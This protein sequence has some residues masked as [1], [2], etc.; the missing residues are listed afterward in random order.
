M[1]AFKVLGD[2]LGLP[3]EDDEGDIPGDENEQ[4]VEEEQSS[5]ENESDDDE[6]EDDDGAAAGDGKSAAD[7]KIERKREREWLEAHFITAKRASD[8]GTVYKSEL[9]PDKVF[10]SK[11]KLKEFLSGKRYKRL[12]HEM[13]K[14]MRTHQDNEKLQKKATER[15]ERCME[16]KRDSEQEKL[17]NKRKRKLEEADDA[18]IARRKAQFQEKKAR[19]LARKAE[20]AGKA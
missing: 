7:A 16:R 15:R 14:G 1:S 3:D 9:L 19:R 11:D 18:E 13:K 17:R 8:G 5:S 12:V 20:A 10:F 2:E 4:E 6:D